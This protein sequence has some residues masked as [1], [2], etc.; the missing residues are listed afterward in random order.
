MNILYRIYKD[1]GTHF[2][3]DYATEELAVKAL[4]VWEKVKPNAKYCIVEIDDNPETRTA[5]WQD[6]KKQNRIL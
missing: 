6:M 1:N 4:L 3:G 5:F 2:D